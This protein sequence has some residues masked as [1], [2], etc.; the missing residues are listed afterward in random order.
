LDLHDPFTVPTRGA[1]LGHVPVDQYA[2]GLA[3]QCPIR[4][5]EEIEAPESLISASANFCL[6]IGKGGATGEN[7]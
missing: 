7:T 6:D 1:A 3:N 4:R 2:G 5:I